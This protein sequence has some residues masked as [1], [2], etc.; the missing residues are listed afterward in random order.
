MEY[1]VKR[2]TSG[3]LKR[4][5]FVYNLK[6]TVRPGVWCVFVWVVEGVAVFLHAVVRVFMENKIVLNLT[7]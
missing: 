6:S 1:V 7:V 5:T 3:N 2:F 4:S